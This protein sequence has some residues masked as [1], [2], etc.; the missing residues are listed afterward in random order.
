MT[1]IINNQVFLGVDNTTVLPCSTS[2]CTGRKSIWLESQ[3]SFLHGLLIGD[4]AH[5]P[6]S[7]CGLW[8]ALYVNFRRLLFLILT[9]YS[10]GQS[11]TAM[12]H[13]ARSISLKA[14]ATYPPHIPPFT[15]IHPQRA[16]SRRLQT[17]KLALQTKE[18]LIVQAR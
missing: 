13:M 6:G 10:A 14:S 1:S 15:Q 18:T 17:R 16:P 9:P 8:P 2:G 7:D 5:M 4:F 11:A 3:D 12:A